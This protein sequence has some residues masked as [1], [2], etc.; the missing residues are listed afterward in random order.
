MTING[1]SDLDIALAELIELEHDLADLGLYHM[2]DETEP[3][4]PAE[5]LW[6]NLYTQADILAEELARTIGDLDNLDHYIEQLHIIASES[7][8]T[9]ELAARFY[10]LGHD[11]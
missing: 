4:T 9:D 11:I 6:V 7:E 10:T 8:D 3:S 2:D 5:H 1:M